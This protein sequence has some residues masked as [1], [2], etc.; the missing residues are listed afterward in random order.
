MT[1]IEPL[2]SDYQNEIR[3]KAEAAASLSK[4]LFDLL[5]FDGRY[6]DDRLKGSP[7]FAR[8]LYIP[9]QVYVCMGSL[10]TEDGTDSEMTH[11]EEIVVDGRHQGW[12]LTRAGLFRL[13]GHLG[14]FK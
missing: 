8:S 13:E 11:T 4:D 2:I 3:G 9:S 14:T 5:H 7:V 1:R 10:R 6:P 12:V